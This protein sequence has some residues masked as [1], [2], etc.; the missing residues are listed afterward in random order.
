[1]GKQGDWKQEGY[2]LKL[3][4]NQDGFFRVVCVS[5]DGELV[6]HANFKFATEMNGWV[7]IV[8]DKTHLEVCTVEIKEDH[9]R[10]G[11]ATAM[12]DLIEEYT[13]ATVLNGI[14]TIS[15]TD[16]AKEFWKNRSK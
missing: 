5:S 2:N 10:K 1:M 14:G 9:R 6:G 15:Q 16:D 7:E 3:E 8:P 12:Y 4:D 11:L 13:G